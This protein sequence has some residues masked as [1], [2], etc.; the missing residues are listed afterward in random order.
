MTLKLVTVGW[1]RARQDR[2][3]ACQH[4]LDRCGCELFDLLPDENFHDF[5]G[6]AVAGLCDIQRVLD[7]LSEDNK[8]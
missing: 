1:T 7:A 8:S 6:D 3:E 5:A 4:W 2:I